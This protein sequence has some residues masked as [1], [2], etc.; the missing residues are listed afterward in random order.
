MQNFDSNE[1]YSKKYLEFTMLNYLR[2]LIKLI[3]KIINT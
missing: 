2:F 1:N 3:F